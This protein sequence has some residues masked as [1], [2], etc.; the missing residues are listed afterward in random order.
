[1]HRGIYRSIKLRFLSNIIMSHSPITIAFLKSN[2]PSF[3][4]GNG[5]NLACC[6]QSPRCYILHCLSADHINEDHL[7]I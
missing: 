1:M 5:S 3:G 2:P 6:L 7:A 4:H